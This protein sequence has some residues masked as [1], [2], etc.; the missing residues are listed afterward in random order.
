DFAERDPDAGGALRFYHDD[1]L[2]SSTLVTDVGGNVV[3]RAAYLPY[4]EPDPS[5]SRD[6]SFTPKYQFNGKEPEKENGLLDYGARMY[7]PAIGRWISPDTSNA[8]GLNRYAYVRNNPVTL[9]DLDGHQ[10]KDPPRWSP[11][12]ESIFAPGQAEKL[13]R[14]IKRGVWEYL[15]D[16]LHDFE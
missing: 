14:T 12:Q 9:T 11:V 6:N 10:S 8:D 1:H 5:F 3:H 2:R 13:D 4:G 16:T 7:Y 15:M